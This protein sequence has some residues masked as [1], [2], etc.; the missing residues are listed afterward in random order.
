M[1]AHDGLVRLLK[2]AHAGEKA[3]AYAYAGHW[4]SVRNQVIRAEIQQIERDEV[5]HRAGLDRMLAE[6]GETPSAPRERLMSVVGRFA[7]VTCFLTGRYGPMWGAGRIEHRNVWEY[8][9]AA[10]L[11]RECG[12]AELVDELLTMAEVEW[13]HHEYFRRHVTVH[14]LRHI[15]RVWP[16]LPPRADIRLPE[17]MTDQTPGRP[18]RSSRVGAAAT[19]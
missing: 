2:L 15:V 7:A 14:W 10:T 13:D 16:D 5:L 12:H 4:R 19:N 3:A 6:L 17:V 9:H 11:A 1:D 8:V 18:G